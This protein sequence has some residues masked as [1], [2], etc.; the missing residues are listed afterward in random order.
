M[1]IHPRDRIEIWET[2][3][4]KFKGSIPE[5]VRFDKGTPLE[6]CLRETDLAIMIYSTVFLDCLRYGI[7]VV[8]LGWYPT[9]WREPLERAGV[10]TFARS[11]K[12]VPPR[13]MTGKAPA[14]GPIPEE[15]FLG[16]PA[17]N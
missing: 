9:V 13:G 12:D 14:K 3:W 2:A 5:Q 4:K 11:L 7:P 1:R 17:L 8:S 15:Y 6:L 16:Q 10:V